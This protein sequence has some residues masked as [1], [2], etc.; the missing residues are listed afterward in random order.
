MH[1]HT[2]SRRP[3][4]VAVLAG[5]AVTAL[6]AGCGHQAKP[7]GVDLNRPPAA[8]TWHSYYGVALPFGAADG[9][10]RHQTTA[11]GFSHN[12][13][14]AALAAIQHDLRMSLAH[15]DWP[16]VGRD[17]LAPGPGK[18]AWVISRDL[19]KLEGPANPA[20]APRIAGYRISSYTPDRA[21]VTIYTIYPDRSIAATD[22]TVTWTDNDWR[23]ALP[24]PESTTVTVH[25]V[26]AIPTGTVPMQDPR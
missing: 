15:E 1:T 3:I 19:V 10:K 24:P 9:P 13:Q 21:A 2:R 8:V 6:L 5:F 17:E 16:L 7:A 12:P 23:L 20:T 18:D 22:T 11:T 4:T 14:G 25:A 26:P